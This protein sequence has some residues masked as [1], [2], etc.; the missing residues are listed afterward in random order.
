MIRLYRQGLTLREVG[1]I[2]GISRQAVQIRLK[3]SGVARRKK[4]VTALVIKAYAAN[5]R[6]ID[7]KL[8]DRLY[9]NEL[10]S[11]KTIASLLGVTEWSVRENLKRGRIPVRRRRFPGLDGRAVLTEA[12]LEKLYSGEN[13]TVRQ[14]AEKTK[15]TQ[16]YVGRLLARFGL[17]KRER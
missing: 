10:K 11:P 1:E 2:A 7:K 13:L 16:A 15:Y 5:R 12:L 17:L 6:D 4:T 9:T 14:I 3:K 8:L